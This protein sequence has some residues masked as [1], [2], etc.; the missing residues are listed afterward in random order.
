MVYYLNKH[1]YE[2]IYLHVR[3]LKDA[4]AMNTSC[5]PVYAT[6]Y[7]IKQGTWTCL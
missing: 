1:I 3:D 2:S 7:R 6:D 5:Y 4:T